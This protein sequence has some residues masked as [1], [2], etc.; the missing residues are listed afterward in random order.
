MQNYVIIISPGA[1][2]KQREATAVGIA[3]LLRKSKHSWEEQ[4][5]NWRS[6]VFSSPRFWT[7]ALCYAKWA[8]E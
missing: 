6:T 4:S 5:A 7:S 8:T 2:A 3:A 1:C